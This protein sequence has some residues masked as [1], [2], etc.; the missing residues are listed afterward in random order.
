MFRL[1]IVLYLAVIVLGSIPGA[2]ADMDEVASGF[3]LHFSTYAVIAFLLACGLRGG[4]L[5]KTAAAFLIIAAMGA[6]DECLQAFLPYRT[7][8]LTDW[9]VDIGAGLFG[10][11]LCTWASGADAA[12]ARN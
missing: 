9:L 1:G 6:L 11:L 2:R 3:V 7:A 12:P 8:A 4:A 5:R 10:G